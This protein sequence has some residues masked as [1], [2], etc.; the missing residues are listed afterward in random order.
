[1][2]VPS[3]PDQL[4]RKLDTL[5]EGP[6]VYLWKD[7][8]GDVLYVGKAKRLRN[9]VRSYFASDFPTSARNQLLQRL[10]ADV[11]T[12]VVP[13]E[14]QSL[15]LENNLITTSGNTPPTSAYATF[16]GVVAPGGTVKWSLGPDSDAGRIPLVGFQLLV[17]GT[18]LAPAVPTGLAA[19]AGSNQVTL[20]WNAVSGANTYTIGRST[21]TGG[22]Y[23]TIS[24][25]AV[26]GL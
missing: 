10:I 19:V 15:I 5:P 24:A 25:G 3:L 13:S 9:R 16:T 23:T 26:T 14:A 11:E 7:A 6:G 21:T 4:Q 1:M 2:S 17:S 20:T 8:A 12:I 18:S 22:P